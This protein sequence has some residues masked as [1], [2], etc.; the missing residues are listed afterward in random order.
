MRRRVVFVSILSLLFIVL[1]APTEARLA[2]APVLV[3]KTNSTRALAV[4]STSR[5][6]EPF[7]P[8]TPV[9]FSQDNRTR[10]ML[11]ATNLT[12]LPGETAANVIATAE[13]GNHIQYPL[14]V[15]YIGSVPSL[16]GVTSVI[17]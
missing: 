12:L 6:A 2:T 10:V 4:E 7:A 5:L 11:F 9:P 17:V 1:L 3:T 13:D 14:T 16:S 8:T 15:E